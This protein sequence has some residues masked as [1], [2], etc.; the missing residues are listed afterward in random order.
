MSAVLESAAT[1]ATSTTAPSPTTSGTAPAP[2]AGRKWLGLFAILAATLMNL[3]DATVVNVAAPAIRTDLGASYTGLQWVAAAYTLTLA[4]GLLTGGRLGDMFGRKRLMQFGAVG[5]VL[6]SLACALAWSPE[7][8]IAA[9]VVQGL[10]G[11]VMI[12]QTFGL[13]RDLFSPQEMG[14]AFAAFGPCIG[15]ATILGPIVA[16]TLVDADLFG[17]GWR[18]IFLINLPLGL[19]ALIAGHKAL[20]AVPPIAAGEGIRSL[21]ALGML[22][23]GTGMFLL[24]YPL[25]QGREQGWPMWM[26][27]ML[28]GA[29]VVLGGFVAQQLR[30]SADG[31]APLVQLSVFKKRSYASGVLFVIAFFGAIT[32]FSLATGLFLQ[33]GNGFSAM[34]AS[35]TMGPWALG[36]FVGS[37]L[38]GALMGKLGRKILHIGLS[39]MAVGILALYAVFTNVSPHVGS[40]PLVAPFLV[41]GLGMGLIFVPLFDIV[42]GEVEDHEVGSASGALESMQ[43]LAAALGVAV[44]GTVFFGHGGAKMFSQDSLDA[45]ALTALV[46]LVLTAAAFALGFLLPKHARQGGGH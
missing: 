32:G 5:F 4:V 17:T 34:R 14:K 27:A 1:P 28:A 12:P 30:R 45:V 41:Y 8:L 6:S 11:A 10:F 35:L 15:I 19:F 43:Q 2:G 36:A 31:K 33:L 16:G 46:S 24:V 38:S 25:V 37:G 9:R 39:I 20:P 21:D 40:W 29:V 22:L 26:F 3:L 18:M 7:S 42:M 44:F 13:I 23:G